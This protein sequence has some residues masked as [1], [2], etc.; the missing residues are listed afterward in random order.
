[1]NGTVR[2]GASMMAVSVL[3]LTGVAGANIVTNGG[4][5]AQGIGGM[6]DAEGWNQI[7]VS[8]GT[9][10][11]VSV[12]TDAS[13]AEGGWHLELSVMGAADGGPLAEAQFQTA[14]FSVTPGDAYDIS[15]WSR[16]VGDLG[17]GAIAGYEVQWLD[18]DG[19]NGGGVKGSTGF[20]GIGG[21]L[22]EDY[23]SFGATGVIAAADSDAAL[24]VLRVVG[25][26][27]DGSDAT[28]YFDGVNLIPAPA[29]ITGL[30]G[31]LLCVRRKRG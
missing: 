8:P 10:E 17:V 25:G 19:S 29:G 15:L 3:G 27:I 2:I 5:E 4:F 7:E 30:A 14:L 31:L 12:R 22:T 28:V 24:V 6:L 16:R 23:Q 11:A 13:P 9:S 20:F 26:A 21:S 1:M 18:S